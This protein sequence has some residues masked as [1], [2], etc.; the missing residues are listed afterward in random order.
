MT[1]TK[2]SSAPFCLAVRER[3]NLITD[4]QTLSNPSPPLANSC[5]FFAQLTVVTSYCF[6]GLNHAT[7]P[8]CTIFC[9]ANF[10]ALEAGKRP[11]SLRNTFQVQGFSTLKT[12]SSRYAR[13]RLPNWDP[14]R[15]RQNHSRCRRSTWSTFFKSLRNAYPTNVTGPGSL[16]LISTRPFPIWRKV[17]YRPLRRERP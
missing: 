3:W 7:L 8:K 14:I 2:M 6:E 4:L 13:S 11:C 1:Y 12:R 9:S 10:R 5:L 16:P 17:S 15:S